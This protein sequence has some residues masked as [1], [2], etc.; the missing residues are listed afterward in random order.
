AQRL[1]RHYGFELTP[2]VFFSHPTLAKLCAYLLS[3]QG[4]RLREFY[5]EPVSVETEGIGLLTFQE[6]W[7]AQELMPSAASSIQ[8]VVCCVEDASQSRA[9]T[10]SVQALDP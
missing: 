3:V 10:Q 2:A 9:I 5:F 6:R 1:S 4:A 7:E 8:S